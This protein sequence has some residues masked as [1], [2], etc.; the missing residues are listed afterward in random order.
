MK[1]IEKTAM[2]HDAPLSE[3]REK[4]INHQQLTISH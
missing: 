1:A 2:E 3:E 4:L